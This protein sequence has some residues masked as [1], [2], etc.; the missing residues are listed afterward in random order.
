MISCCLTLELL[1][2]TV[3]N[4]HVLAQATACQSLSDGVWNA[5]CGH[6]SALFVSASVYGLHL[7][8]SHSRYV[9]AS[10]GGEANSAG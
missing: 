10:A 2:A 8:P 6:A 1:H 4:K 3:V 9:V 7:S 5:H